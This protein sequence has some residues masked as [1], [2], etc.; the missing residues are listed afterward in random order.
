MPAFRPSSA[1][2]GSEY[3]QTIEFDGLSPYGFTEGLSPEFTQEVSMVI[4]EQA[5]DPQFTGNDLPDQ[6]PLDPQSE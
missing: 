5:S 1:A 3:G 2:D 6:P 4:I